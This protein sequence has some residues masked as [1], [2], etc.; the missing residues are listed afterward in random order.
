MLRMGERMEKT[1]EI[2]WTGFPIPAV[3]LSKTAFP[4]LAP[5]VSRIESIE[6][7]FLEI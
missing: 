3:L 4:C 7:S 5:S 2:L 1:R 6:K